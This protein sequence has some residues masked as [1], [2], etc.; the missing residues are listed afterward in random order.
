VTHF[1]LERLDSVALVT[2]DDGSGQ[3]RPNVLGRAAL[4]SLAALLPDLEDGDFSALV[5]TGKP[6]SFAAGADLDEFP[7]IERREQAIEGSRAGHELFGR[8]RG[9]PYPT[10][11]AIN[12]GALGGG[13][14]LALHCDYRVIGDDVRHFASPEC[15]LGFVPGWGGTQ[16]SPRI[17]GPEAAVKL[18]ALNPM[19]QNKM[20]TAEQAFELG[21]VDRVVEP[22]S[23]VE[24][25]ISIAT[26]RPE[27]PEADLSGTGEAV[28]KARSQLD[29]SI[30]GAAPAPYRALDLIE[31]AA[32][33]GIEEGYEAEREALADLLF[34]PEAQAS[35]YAFDL[36]ER[37]ARRGAGRPDAE[38]REVQ[39]VGLA[40]AGLMATQ[41]ATL[42]LRRLK[43]PVVLRDLDQQIIDRALESIRD[44]LAGAA[45]R[46]RIDPQEAVSLAALAKGTTSYEGFEDCDFVLEAIFEELDVKRQALGELEQV[47]SADCVLATN[48][49]ALSVSA[50]AEGLEHPERLVGMHFFNPVALM[51]LVELIRTGE[52]DEAALATSWALAD[53][54]RKRPVL[55]NDAPGFVVNRLLTRMMVVLLDAIERGSSVEE[56]DEA[57][58]SLGLPMAPSVL[59]QMVGEQVATHVRETLQAA[60]PDRFAIT[61]E[62]PV[63]SV[64]EL[65]DAVLAAL[66]DEVG[67][68]LEEGVVAS[69]KDVDAAL[70]LGAG[71]PF[72]MGGLT[73]RLEQAG[74]SYEPS[75][76][77][78]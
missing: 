50:M 65:R 41:L 68:M 37:R 77:R 54:L 18:I 60:H 66:A 40:G 9:L 24:E 14:E 49:S 73:K 1:R 26:E 17:A 38:P 31:G 19:R 10:V 72:F 78:A 55:V 45:H 21:F 63:H 35:L 23:L 46:G 2:M 52:T 56:T 16:L 64:D 48:T 27:R 36:I 29:D 47:V 76:T 61:G 11:A 39:K 53:R 44:D 20:L 75:S 62:G 58:L 32:T 13:V 22:T 71:F 7:R 34:T 69:P 3:G 12:G 74:Y 70:I 67:H 8:I 51:P 5:V 6:G 57:V 25:A 59:L 28:R 4:E 43:V 15:L 42:F 33:W 30:H